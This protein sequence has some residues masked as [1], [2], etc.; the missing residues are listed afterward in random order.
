MTCP[1]YLQSTTVVWPPASSIPSWQRGCLW[2]TAT[3][4]WSIHTSKSA[5]CSQIWESTSTRPQSHSQMW[6]STASNP[7]FSFQLCSGVSAAIAVHRGVTE[8][9]VYRTK[10]QVW[11]SLCGK[12]IDGWVAQH[13]IWN[14]A[15]GHCQKLFGFFFILVQFPEWKV[16]SS[17]ENMT[18]I[19]YSWKDSV[20]SE[21]STSPLRHDSS[22]QDW[23]RR[24]IND[25]D[26]KQI[27]LEYYRT[28]TCFQ[29]FFINS[30]FFRCF[31]FIQCFIIFWKITMQSEDVRYWT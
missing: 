15:K 31:S 25:A 26:T 10:R 12:E 20:Q 16:P 9:L 23:C 28:K 3:C 8:T 6:S 27:A 11:D 14:I 2:I 4:L 30:Y 5:S 22:I 1:L 19:C 29:L 13:Y 21:K 18:W 7:Q 24:C 17:G